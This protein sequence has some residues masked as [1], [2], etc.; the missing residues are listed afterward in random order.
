MRRNLRAAEFCESFLL[1][2]SPTHTHTDALVE[3]LLMDQKVN[4]DE[5]FSESRP[6]AVMVLA[7]S[8]FQIDISKSKCS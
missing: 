8:L 2:L 1:V 6:L 7:I 4:S 3:I 5:V